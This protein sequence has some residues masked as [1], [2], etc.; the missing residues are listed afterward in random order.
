VTAISG[1]GIGTPDPVRATSRIASSAS[2]LWILSV[3]LCAPR[4]VG[5]K[6]TDTSCVAPGA[7]VAPAPPLSI[8]NAAPEEAVSAIELT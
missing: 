3:A 6:R 1:S 7:S 8:E 2:S 4:L 5:A